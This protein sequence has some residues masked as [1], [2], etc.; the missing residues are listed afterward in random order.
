MFIILLGDFNID[1]SNN[2]ALGRYNIR[3]L[4]ELYGLKQVI[5]ETT[6]YGNKPSIIDYTLTNS[7]CIRKHGVMHPNLSDHELIFITRKKLKIK[8][9][10][11]NTFGRSYKKYNKNDFQGLLMD[12][13]WSNLDRIN[14]PS[15]YWRTLLDGITSEIEKLCPLNKMV[16]RDYGDPW[17]TREI[18][19][20]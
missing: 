14:N 15:D 11:I 7:D 8:Y 1:Y 4:E 2:R 19:E 16:L 17:V 5:S 9:N 20:V 6:R 10:T 13:D 12:H 18:V 3:D